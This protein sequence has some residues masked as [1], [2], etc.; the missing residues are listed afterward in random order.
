MNR[1]H[2]FGNERWIWPEAYM[3]LYNHFAQFRRD[4]VLKKIGKKAILHITADKSYKL[5]VN[6]QFVCRGPAR[7]YQSHW[8]YD[9]VDLRPYL[10]RG[11]NWIS[12][13]AYMPGISTFCYIHKTRAGLLTAPEGP[14]LETAWAATKWQ[15]RRSPAHATDTAR[16]SL[17][18]DFQEHVDFAKDDRKWISSATPPEKWDPRFF[19]PVGQQ[20]LSQPF[21][22]PPYTGVEE[23]GIPMLREWVRPPQRVIRWGT[24]TSNPGYQSCTNV[25]WFAYEELQGIKEWRDGTGVKSIAAF[26]SM[27]LHLEPTGAGKFAA[28]CIDVGEYAGANLIVQA[29][30]AAG[31]EI[32]DFQYDQSNRERNAKT[33]SPGDACA[34]AMAGR[35]KLAP[36]T[37]DHEFYQLL[38][39]QHLTVIARDLTQPI[40]LKISLRCAGYPFAFRGKFACSDTTLNRIH[41][42]CTRTQQLCS[43]DAY[44]D[45]PW[46]EQAQWWGDARV[47]ARNTF[48]MDG[49]ARLVA[50]GV[51]SIAGQLTTHGLTYGH[52]PTSSDWCILPDFSLTWIMTVWDHYY[53]TGS[54]ELFKEQWPTIEGVLAYFR[55]EEAKGKIGLLQYDG[56]FWLFEDWAELPKEKYP[57]FL[58]LWYLLTLRHVCKLLEVCR[59]RPSLAAYRKLADE[60]EKLILRHYLD[61]KT[62]LIRP[63]LDAKGKQQGEPSVHDQALALMLGIAKEQHDGMIAEVVLPFLRGEGPKGAKPSAFWSFYVLEE[64]GRRG[65]GREVIEY[66][67]RNWAQMIVTGTTWEGFDSMEGSG[68]STCHAYSAHPSMHFV[69]VLAGIRQAAPAWE[70]IIFAPIFVREIDKA[71]A[72][73]PSPAGD[74]KASWKRTKKGISGELRLPAGVTATIEL[75]GEKPRTV[76]GG[77]HPFVK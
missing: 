50:R 65:F 40:T 31:G 33:V 16:L 14:E 62:G 53:Q 26:E 46:R 8:P 43:W 27:T 63:V 7:G 1:E 77:V 6:G 36:G 30:G 38:G 54:A 61:A 66:I 60:Q 45:T 75:P 44:M 47:Q 9:T 28:I 70:K 23:R 34:V 72:L 37:N 22:T 58:N 56:R 76:T 2:P 29:S 24:G 3:Y 20:F 71:Q 67:R 15:F 25:S 68:S 55:T 32:L 10:R 21:G 59:M 48:Y 4:L 39:F 41:Y 35:L 12:V 52:A 13:E 18:I 57:A 51:R 42:A 19:P 11:H 69:N 17:Q 74:I 5:F 73:V 64:M 49:D